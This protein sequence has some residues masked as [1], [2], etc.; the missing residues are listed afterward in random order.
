MM[1]DKTSQC[2]WQCVCIGVWDR[3][4]GGGGGEGEEMSPGRRGRSC[5]IPETPFQKKLKVGNNS[6]FQQLYSWFSY[7]L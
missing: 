4:G 1:L 5:Q 7:S 2:Q 6:Y 3:R